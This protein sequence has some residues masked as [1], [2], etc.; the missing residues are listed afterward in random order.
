MFEPLIRMNKQ[1]MSLT[2]KGIF[3]QLFLDPQFTNLIIQLNTEN[4]LFEKGVRSDGYPLWQIDQSPSPS[5]EFSQGG[6]YAKSTE[7]GIP[8]KFVGKK[9]KG[10]P[11]D[12]ITLYDK[13]AFYK[14]FKCYW[15]DSGNGGIRIS[16]QTI[17]DGFDLMDRFGEEILGLTEDSLSILREVARTK[18]KQIV[19]NQIKKAA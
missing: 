6:V 14:S 5:R 11:I 4:Q 15:E 2:V 12:R 10:L 16:A 19:L 18:L 1:I 17:K 13:G 8:G 3:V 9:E 7:D